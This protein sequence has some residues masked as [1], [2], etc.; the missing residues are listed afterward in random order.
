MNLIYGLIFLVVFI[1]FRIGLV[2]YMVDIFKIF[3]LNINF[4]NFNGIENIY[5]F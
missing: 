2:R 4:K 1:R 3:I 5:F